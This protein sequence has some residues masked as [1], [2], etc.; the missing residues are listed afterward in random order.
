MNNPKS[1]PD[2]SLLLGA[3][4][5]FALISFVCF[6]FAIKLRHITKHNP[7]A[8]VQLTPQQEIQQLRA[9]LA[10]I[11]TEIADAKIE[12]A[13]V[14]PNDLKTF[15]CPLVQNNGQG[16]MYLQDSN[17]NRNR[18]MLWGFRADGVVLWKDPLDK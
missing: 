12:A 2:I 11:K 1:K 7:T 3:I 5:T 9:E 4:V 10:E 14:K 18:I 15:W 16:L 13:T 6:C 8:E 17:G